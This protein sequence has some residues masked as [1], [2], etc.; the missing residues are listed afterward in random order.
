MM[1][2]AMMAAVETIERRTR[3]KIMTPLILFLLG[4]PFLQLPPLVDLNTHSSVL[5]SKQ[6]RESA[7]HASQLSVLWHVNGT[8][9][10]IMN[11]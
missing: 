4:Q 5:R 7:L 3:K 9:C 1:A 2:P 10:A 11:C 6:Q 8:V